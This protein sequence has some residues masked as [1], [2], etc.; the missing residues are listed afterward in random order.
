MFADNTIHQ[1]LPTAEHSKRDS[2]HFTKLLSPIALLL[3]GSC[4]ILSL[5]AYLFGIYLNTSHS[6]PIGFYRSISNPMERGSFVAVC[7]SD[8]AARF[9]LE[10][11]YIHQGSCENGA[12]PVLKRVIAMSGDAVRLKDTALFV[13]DKFITSA[14]V[15]HFDSHGRPL[16][17]RNEFEMKLSPQELFLFSDHDPR[18]WDSRYF[19]P[20]TRSQIISVVTPLLIKSDS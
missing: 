15:Q 19:G 5:I 9:G 4:F 2:K 18:S 14:S 10:R 17:F 1:L 11:G 20:V 3:L 16:E 13:N 6:A 8:E 7:L 12:E